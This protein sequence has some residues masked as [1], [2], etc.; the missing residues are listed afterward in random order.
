LPFQCTKVRQTAAKG[1]TKRNRKNGC[2]NKFE[3]DLEL[4]KLSAF[5]ATIEEWVDVNGRAE[6]QEISPRLMAGGR[7]GAL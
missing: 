3:E 2:F 5:L 1:G 4:W 7:S 6:T